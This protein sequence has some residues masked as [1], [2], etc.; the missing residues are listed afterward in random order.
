MA[1]T[2]PFGRDKDEDPLASMGWSTAG[3]VKPQSGPADIAPPVTPDVTAPR[4]PDPTGHGPKWK[5]QWRF[6][7]GAGAKRTPARGCATAIFV[8]LF[9]GIAASV[10]VPIA[11]EVGDS[12]DEIERIDPRAP[13]PPSTPGDRRDRD[14]ERGPSRAPRGL[15]AASMLRR[16]NL[17]P[18]L[19]RLQRLTRSRQVTL[20]RIDA[21][22]VIVKALSRDGRARFAQATWEGEASILSSS[23]RGGDT[24]FPWSRVDPSAPNRL[25][26]TATRGRSSRA[27]DYVVLIDPAGPLGLQWTGFVKG[28]GDPVAA[29][30]DGRPQ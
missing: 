30:P 23:P 25:V 4:A 2:D 11:I 24:Y 20:V 14:R 13:D 28:G 8:V 10:V 9:L 27:I 6:D 21:E 18:A 19:R 16:G 22:D 17:A 1:D 15:E 7:R 29:G 26:R 3:T 5:R 12:V